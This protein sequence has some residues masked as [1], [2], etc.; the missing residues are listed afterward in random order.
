MGDQ[1][2]SSEKMSLKTF[3]RGQFVVR[4]RNKPYLKNWSLST[5]DEVN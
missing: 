2:L 4:K 5:P 3:Q 1:N